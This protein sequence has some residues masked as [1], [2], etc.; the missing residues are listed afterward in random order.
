MGED[1]A[2][3]KAALMAKAEALIEA[4]LRWDEETE[5]PNLGQLETEIL[6][7]RQAFGE[8]LLEDV[9]TNQ[10]QVRP[11]PGPRCEQCGQEMSYKG[12]K[13][14]EVVSLAGET[15]IE[16]GYY[17]CRVCGSGFFPPG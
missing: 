4:M 3:R 6:K 13:G 8:E 5:A 1:R 9:V 11:V 16:R 7:L 14:K 2:K 15:R 10:E 17:Y 12:Q